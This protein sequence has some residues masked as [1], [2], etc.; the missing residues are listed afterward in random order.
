MATT[1]IRPNQRT[2]KVGC[3]GYYKGYCKGLLE[4]KRQQVGFNYWS[5]VQG[6]RAHLLLMFL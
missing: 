6:S 3:S 5:S 1:Q 4:S 2:F